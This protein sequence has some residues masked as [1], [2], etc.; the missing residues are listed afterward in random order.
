MTAITSSSTPAEVWAAFVDNASYDETDDRTKAKTFRTVL[1]VLIG[2][3]RT[4]SAG[5]DGQTLSME[6]LQQML[7][8]VN[9]WIHANPDPAAPGRTRYFAMENFRG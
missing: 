2:K 4:M 3:Y 9:A 6:S 7:A 1:R 8:D 5:R